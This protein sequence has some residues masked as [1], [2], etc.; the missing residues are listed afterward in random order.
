MRQRILPVLITLSLFAAA[1]AQTS[2]DKAV[3]KALEPLYARIA[4]A[5]FNRDIEGF[6][7]LFAPPGTARQGE[8]VADPQEAR[9]RV[10]MVLAMV[11]KMTGVKMQIVQVTSK[12]DRAVVINRYAYQGIVEPEKGR[13]V[14]M[15]DRGTMKITWAKT[16]KGWRILNVDT[17]D[18]NPTMDGKPMKGT[19]PQAPRPGTAVPPKK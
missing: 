19:M 16:A 6:M 10:G 11:K 18:S 7:G 2:A 4:K 15:A 1:S 8:K 12:G 9:V 17:I 3:R 14:K 5:F 13:T